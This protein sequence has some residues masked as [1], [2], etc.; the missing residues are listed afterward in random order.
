MC[1][2]QADLMTVITTKSLVLYVYSGRD[3]L[4]KYIIVENKYE[5]LTLMALV[6]L[7]LTQKLPFSTFAFYAFSWWL[8]YMTTET[9]TELTLIMKY[10]STAVTSQEKASV[11]FYT[12]SV[13][14]VFGGAFCRKMRAV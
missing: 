9:F 3:T 12:N 2:N 1:R 13:F 14:V 5:Q 4:R 10:L 11:R 8:I 7:I 6:P